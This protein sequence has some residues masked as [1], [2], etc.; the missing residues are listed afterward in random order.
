IQQVPA[1]PA[2]G[3][4]CFDTL[5]SAEFSPKT[6]WN[7]IPMCINFDISMGPRLDDDDLNAIYDDW[8]DPWGPPADLPVDCSYDYP[9]TINEDLRSAPTGGLPA[10]HVAEDSSRLRP[11]DP[12][13][14]R[15]AAALGRP[16]DAFQIPT[17][18]P[19][20]PLGVYE[21]DSNALSEPERVAHPEDWWPWPDAPTATA[22]QLSAFPRSLFSER[23]MD[24]VVWLAR[25]CGADIDYTVRQLNSCR[26]KVS[27]DLG[28]TRE[29]RVGAH[30]NPFAM[31]DFGKIIADEWANPCVR[32]H[33][34]TYA[35][36]AGERLSAPYDGTKWREEVN[37]MLS[38]PMVRAENG[39]DY[40]V[41][42]PAL[43][44]VGSSV[45]AVMPIR[46]F[47]R[48]GVLWGR[49]KSLVVI[50]CQVPAGVFAVDERIDCFELPLS[51]FFATCFI[52]ADGSF[53]HFPIT[54]PN[55]L[56][57]RAAGKRIYSPPI[58]AY[59]DDTS[60]NMSK[61]WNKHNSL[62]FTLAGLPPELAHLLYNIHFL[63]TSNIASPL[64]MFE[65][66]VEQLRAIRRQ[67]G[68]EVYDCVH[69]E[70]VLLLPW[71]L[72]MNGDNPMQSEFSSHIGLA[73]KCFCRVCFARN[74]NKSRRAGDDVESERLEMFM[75]LQEDNA[76]TSEL[77]MQA[78]QS[79]L[80]AVLD[81]AP[82][83]AEKLQTET[84]VKDKYFQ[85]FFEKLAAECS[86]I[87]EQQTG[88][89]ATTTLTA[90]LRQ[91]R[92]T[93]PENLFNPALHVE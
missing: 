58:W 37:A 85:Y 88:E 10:F 73:G 59:C 26:D 29:M 5:R 24:T 62:L 47:T 77:T 89:A 27:R 93:M 72:G 75:F 52:R 34:R 80:D 82:T 57:L 2:T 61:K 4:W 13:S 81:G 68:I 17:D 56:R 43:V 66:L 18:D 84:G 70:V 9:G 49:V 90:A 15:E 39:R 38:G 69:H 67:G 8:A 60:G 55:Q 25:Q 78:L 45:E 6:V 76:R 83:R 14:K 92:D 16:S 21:P 40:Y 23:D 33:I 91:L 20:P 51:V 46:W 11:R 28:P 86:R 65:A 32:P 42:E 3:N 50:P 1:Y 41:E 71:I 22:T 54:A 53:E 79:Q 48:D 36:E 12:C 63:A 31:L 87:K 7:T 44:K 35:E 74:D 64:E 19:T 30:G